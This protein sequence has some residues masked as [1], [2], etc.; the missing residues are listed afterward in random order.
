MG[1]IEVLQDVCEICGASVSRM[2]EANPN[3]ATLLLDRMPK[4]LEW[5]K[6]IEE[7]LG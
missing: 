5:H 6:A 3:G 1:D 2:V 4:H 7:E